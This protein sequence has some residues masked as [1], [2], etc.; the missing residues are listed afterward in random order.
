MK[1]TDLITF[2]RQGRDFDD[3][4]RE[5]ALDIES[6]VIEIYAK[7]PVSI[8]S[9]LGFFPI[10]KSN[11]LIEFESQGADYQ[12]LFDFFYFLDVIEESKGTDQSTDAE[13]AR[14]LLS[15]SIEDA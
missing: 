5:Q 6:E 11:G 1:L 10:E 12:N 15:Y 4:C 7:K 8:D 9:E 13:L 3:F 14:K 2:F